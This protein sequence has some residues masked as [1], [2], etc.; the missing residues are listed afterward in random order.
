[1]PLPDVCLGSSYGGAGGVAGGAGGLGA[2]SQNAT[3][4]GSSDG[5]GLPFVMLTTNMRKTLNIGLRTTLCGGDPVDL[6][7]VASARYK[8]KELETSPSYYINKVATMATPLSDGIVQVSFA[9]R[10]IPFAG[11]W[12]AAVQ[13]LNADSEVTDEFRGFLEVRWGMNNDN[14]IQ[15][16]RPLG[17]FEV[18]MAMRDYCPEYNTL[19]DDLEFSDSEI[20]LAITRV[21]DEWNDTA[22]TLEQY[23]YTAATFPWRSPWLAMTCAILLRNAA[24]RYARN[25]LPYSAGGVN[26]DDMNKAPAYIQLSKDLEQKWNDWMMRTKKELNIGLCYGAVKSISF[27]SPFYANGVF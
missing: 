27:G 13:L 25:Q 1:M 2:A 19:L 10:D 18:R 14:R 3:G 23:T 17:I 21:V 15:V 20:A 8:A 24:H 22:P 26:V 4:S 7:G 16:A 6:T 9:P 11:I 5:S 12:P